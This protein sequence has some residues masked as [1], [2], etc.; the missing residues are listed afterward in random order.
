MIK[1]LFLSFV[2]IKGLSYATT[3]EGE[4]RFGPIP[5]IERAAFEVLAE[6]MSFH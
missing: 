2:L 1:T 4:H 6:R 5:V 3:E